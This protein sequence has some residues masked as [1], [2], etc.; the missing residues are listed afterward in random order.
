M[1]VAKKPQER[2]LGRAA[3]ILLDSGGEVGRTL[4]GR[5]EIVRRLGEGA[6]AAVY[7]ARDRQLDRRVAVKILSDALRSEGKLLERF[8]REALI[9]ARL[10]HANLAT[11]YDVGEDDGTPYIAMELVEGRTL[12]ELFAD[13]ELSL[14]ARV[15]LLAKVADALHY[16]HTQGVVHRDLKPQNILVDKGGEPR[17]VDFGLAHVMEGGGTLTRSGAVL[18][19]PLYM[20]PEQVRGGKKIDA[21]S[22]VWSLGVILYEGLVGRVPF[23]ADRLE[24]LYRLILLEEPRALRSLVRTLPADL[25]TVCLKA[26]EKEPGRRY[27]SARALAEDLRRWLGGEPIAARPPSVALRLRRLVRRRPFAAAMALAVLVGAAVIGGMV[28]VQR[29][30]ARAAAREE[31]RRQWE[32]AQELAGVHCEAAIEPLIRADQS[33]RQAGDEELVYAINRRLG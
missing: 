16:A 27:V 30:S 14:R 24:T 10:R 32:A 31:A 23:T 8:H 33:A 26:L 18:G 20:S 3:R 4:A 29:G 13:H 6:M 2:R 5:Y 7:E 21:R 19:T 9:V 15:V 11:V 28:V 1:R 17:V 25:E 22:D 12:A